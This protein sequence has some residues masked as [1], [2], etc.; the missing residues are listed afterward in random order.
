MRVLDAHG[1]CPVASLWCVLVSGH[2]S[3]PSRCLGHPRQPASMKTDRMRAKMENLHAHPG[4]HVMQR[5]HDSQL[6]VQP[7]Q[8]LPQR[9][10]Q[11]GQR[12]CQWMK[13]LR[14]HVA[15]TAPSHAAYRAGVHLL[16]PRPLTRFLLVGFIKLTSHRR[17]RQTQHTQIG[18]A[19]IEGFAAMG[20]KEWKVFAD[21]FEHSGFHR[22]FPGMQRF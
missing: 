7:P 22:P 10:V 13:T 9:A 20:H 8:H 16:H 17:T 3:V 6:A 19:Q 1:S 14:L 2:Q 21:L 12:N 11:P 5:C 4:K 15:Q 18:S